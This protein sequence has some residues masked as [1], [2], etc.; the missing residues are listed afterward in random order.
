MAEEFNHAKLKQASSFFQEVPSSNLVQ[1]TTYC[2]TLYSSYA[3]ATA[4][5]YSAVYKLGSSVSIVI[6]LW[7]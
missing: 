6:R 4:G 5:Q 3:R 7:A 2:L 1:T